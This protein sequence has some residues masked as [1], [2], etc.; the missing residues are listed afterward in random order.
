MDRRAWQGIVD[1][2]AANALWAVVLGLWTFGVAML[3]GLTWGE[4]G[5]L[6]AGG[7][8]VCLFI[9]ALIGVRRNQA[10]KVLQPLGNFQ[11]MSL[12]RTPDG[13]LIGLEGGGGTIYATIDQSQ[14]NRV[15]LGVR[16][17]LT[18]DPSAVMFTERQIDR[19]SR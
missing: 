6:T 14:K 2:L 11:G 7:A 9:A 4:I 15:W 3:G 18:K 16:D 1:G 12:F 13:R 17:V 19:W 8:A 5:T 10:P